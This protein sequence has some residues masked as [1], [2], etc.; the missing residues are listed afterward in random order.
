[1]I[2]WVDTIHKKVRESGPSM[3]PVG[4]A[5]CASVISWFRKFANK[6]EPAGLSKA[7]ANHYEVSGFLDWNGRCWYFNTGDCRFNLMDGLLIRKA[8]DHKDFGGRG[9]PN[10]FV[11]YDENFEKNLRAILEAR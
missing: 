8:V 10:M 1:M 5:W 6:L 9:G 7:H 11:K 2:T 3:G 4:T